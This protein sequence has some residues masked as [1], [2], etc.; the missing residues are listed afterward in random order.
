[1]FNYSSDNHA[2][3][4]A[5]MDIESRSLKYVEFHMFETFSPTFLDQM[6]IAGFWH[7]AEGY[8]QYESVVENAKGQAGNPVSYLFPPFDPDSDEYDTYE[9]LANED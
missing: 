8:P 2:L 4:L 9:F 1:M 7:D 5:I 3:T 6:Q